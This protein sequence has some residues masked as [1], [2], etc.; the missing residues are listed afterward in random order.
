MTITIRRIRTGEAGLFKSLRLAAL[1][2][3][4]YAFSSTYESARQRSPSS[5]QLQ[6]DS[7]AE[8][9][10]RATFL[11]FS[12]EVPIGLTSAYR[13]QD[14]PDEAEV[15]QV[16]V[17]PHYRGSQVARELLE[18]ALRWCESNGIRRVMAAVTTGNDRALRFYS[19]HGFTAQGPASCGPHGSLVLGRSV[20]ADTT[21]APGS[22]EGSPGA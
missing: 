16:W 3:S 21:G 4:P 1:K 13:S 18:A 19:K 17:A 15:L 11:A 9:T 20:G 7:T 14:K 2:E 5:W 12:D 8:G 22:T 6:A 10:D